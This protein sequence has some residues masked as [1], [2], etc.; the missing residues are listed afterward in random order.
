MKT[1]LFIS[2]L[3]FVCGTAQISQAAITRPSFDSSSNPPIYTEPTKPYNK[4]FR[5]YAADTERNDTNSNTATV[6]NAV[7]DSHISKENLNCYTKGDGLMFCVDEKGKPYTGRRTVMQ[8]ETKYLSIENYRNGYKDGLCTYFD[9]IGQ[10]RE[11][12][13][14]KQGIKNGTHKIYYSDNNI[15]ILAN[16]KDGE[17]DGM[18]DVYSPEGELLGR[19]KYKKG[20]MVKGFCKNNG[21]KEEFKRETLDSHPYNTLESCGTSR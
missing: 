1:K 3:A 7:P 16:Y 11:R 2:A 18:S 4:N 9:E 14:Y 6:P 5:V 21:K 8:S 17:I 12:S 20:Y 19:I 13:Y 15:K 10:R